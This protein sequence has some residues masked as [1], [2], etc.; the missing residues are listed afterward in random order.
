MKFDNGAK[1]LKRINWSGWSAMRK[2]LLC[3]LSVIMAVCMA[4]V[5]AL[6]VKTLT[7]SPREQI[8]AR[9]MRQIERYGW[10]PYSSNMTIDEFYALME[11][12]DEGKLP[13]KQKSD[14]PAATDADGNGES[15]STP[16]TLIIPRDRFLL[17][18][19]P[20]ELASE[21]MIIDEEN[22]T[23]TEILDKPLYYDRDYRYEP[24][25]PDTGTAYKLG[26]NNKGENKDG[27]VFI[28]TNERG[29][30]IQLT[31]RTENEDTI[32]YKYGRL[33]SEKAV[34]YEHFDHGFT[35]NGNN[36]V[37]YEMEERTETNA[38]G[39]KFVTYG[40]LL[41]LGT[42]EEYVCL[43]N[44]I[45]VNWDDYDPSSGANPE[46]EVTEKTY[47]YDGGKLYEYDESSDTKKGEAYNAAND[48]TLHLF[49]KDGSIYRVQ[50]QLNDGSHKLTLFDTEEWETTDIEFVDLFTSFTGVEYELSSDGKLYRTGTEN[51]MPFSE[52]AGE[53]YR[54]EI[55]GV[56]QAYEWRDGVMYMPRTNIVA[57][58]DPI[59]K[60]LSYR[61]P[62]GYGLQYSG[63]LRPPKDW[64]GVKVEEI[65]DVQTVLVKKGINDNNYQISCDVDQSVFQGDEKGNGDYEHGI[66]Y[67]GYYIKQITIDGANVNI[68]G[69]IRVPETG[70][71]VYYYLSAEEQDWQVST[72]TL[73]DEDKFLI[74]YTPNEYKI[75]YQVLMEG[76]FVHGDDLTSAEFRSKS[77]ANLVPQ[78]VVM[79]GATSAT[80]LNWVDSIFGT[81]SNRAARTTGG[82]YSFDVLV[83]YGYEIQIYIS[84]D[85]II[86]GTYKDKY[87]KDIPD[88]AKEPN[89]DGAIPYTF[90]VD[91][92]HT[93]SRA[94]VEETWLN[95]YRKYLVENGIIDSATDFKYVRTPSAGFGEYVTYKWED[96]SDP[97][98]EV[99]NGVF[100]IM[101]ERINDMQMH[102]S[103][104][105]YDGHDNSQT[106]FPLGKEPEYSYYSGD[107]FNVFADEKGPAS[108]TMNDTFY[109]HFV[110]ANRMI[111]AV[112]K[113]RKVDETP[114]FDVSNILSNSDGAKDRASSATERFG[115]Q[116][117]QPYTKLQDFSG[118]YY[119]ADYLW[120][121]ESDHG[122]LTEHP[123][124]Y[125]Y[126]VYANVEN[127][128][129]W[130]WNKEDAT[131]KGNS[132]QMKP[133]ER[134]GTYYYS[135]VF[136]TN[137]NGGPFTLDALEVNGIP[138]YVPYY[139]KYRYDN[140]G[141]T[142]EDVKRPYFTE[143]KLQ[144]G[145][146][147]TVEYLM[148]FGGSN[149][150]VYR[151]TV[152]GARQNVTVTGL[153][154]M[155]GGG[156]PEFSVYSLSGV[157]D[158]VGDQTD[159]AIQYYHVNGY[160]ATGYQ[161]N[162]VV[163][164]DGSPKSGIRT[165]GDGAMYGANLRFKIAD[166][167]GSPYYMWV[168]T[169]DEPINNQT[170]LP[171]KVD[172]NGNK[173][174]DIGNPNR[175]VNWSEVKQK[176]SDWTD[177]RG[178]LKSQYI[179][180]MDDSNNDDY[181]YYYIHVAQPGELPDSRICLLTVVA[182]TVKYTVRYTASHDP[183]DA[184]IV[185]PESNKAWYG[186]I[187]DPVTGQ[188]VVEVDSELELQYMRYNQKAPNGKN[189]LLD[190]SETS[191]PTIIHDRSTCELVGMI[192]PNVL[193]EWIAVIH[194]YDDNGGAFY[195]MIYNTRASIMSNEY[196]TIRPKDKNN[197]YNFV[198]WVLVDEN[199]LPY[200]LENGE[201]IYFTSGV[202]DLKVY[203]E[204]AVKHS[205]F[206]NDETDIMVFRLMP[207]W[208]PN[209]NP[210]SYS[211][212][213][214]WVDAKGTLSQAE[215][216]DWDDV[217]TEA[218]IGDQLFVFL[219]KDSIPLQNWIASHPTYVFWDA[220]NNATTQFIRDD[221][222]NLI[223]DE[224]GNP[225]RDRDAN[226]K[227]LK[228]ALE[229]YL[230]RQYNPAVYPQ[231]A[232][233]LQ[234]LVNRDYSGYNEA[235][236]LTEPSKWIEDEGGSFIRDPFTNEW[237]H[238]PY[239]Y[240]PGGNGVD[241]FDRLD[242]SI[243]RVNENG[244]T[245][246]IWMYETK[247]GLLFKKSV[248]VEPFT[249]DDEFYFSVIN[250]W[251][252]EKTTDK[253]GN[254]ITPTALLGTEAEPAVYKAYPLTYYN[255]E[256][257][258]WGIYDENGKFVPA[259]DE[260]SML[261]TF[262]NGEIVSIE[263]NGKVLTEKD[264]D[265]YEITGEDGK[266][267]PVTYFTLTN[268][269]GIS[270]YVPNGNYTIVET[271]SKSGGAYQAEVDYTGASEFEENIELPTGELW[272]K[273]KNKHYIPLGEG[274]TFD[275]DKYAGVSQI[276]V[277]VTFLT[278][279]EEIIQ[280]L[281][282]YNRTN[283]L[284]VG[285]SLDESVYKT[286]DP[287][288]S[289][290]DQANWNARYKG[291]YNFI[292]VFA[293]P[294]GQ[295]PLVKAQS[296]SARSATA[297]AAGEE[298]FFNMNIYDGF[299]DNREFVTMKEVIF[300][301]YDADRHG[302]P[303]DIVLDNYDNLWI[304]TFTLRPEQSAALVMQVMTGNVNYWV[305]EP[306]EED[307][308]LLPNDL[309]PKWQ[310][311]RRRGEAV[312]GY[313]NS[314]FVTNYWHDQVPEDP[315]VADYGYLKITVSGGK[316]GESFLFRITNAD[317]RNISVIVSVKS[318]ESTYVY[319][320]I[321][322]YVVEEISG[323]AW[324]YNALG[325]FN[326]DIGADNTRD[327]PFARQFD[328]S[329]N[330]KGWLG[331]ENNEEWQWPT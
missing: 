35:K 92:D 190:T 58:A 276:P 236:V 196:G 30:K 63:Y 115:L 194:Q 32:L 98:A 296:E 99:H 83:P 320:P 118:D 128:G 123:I 167:Y 80:T 2:F 273:G 247:G 131:F 11:L 232:I 126:S 57:N 270:L 311:N 158:G 295:T 95:G 100:Q 18:G 239:I 192:D 77:I 173:T 52:P 221:N 79:Y 47:I 122:G 183:D 82:A 290:N 326:A 331:S 322:S 73:R 191:L 306:V 235:G 193:E 188:L 224:D 179:Y 316:S 59:I 291:D 293:L 24:Y 55:D 33:Y 145:S 216:S 87:N 38:A 255:E 40:K 166:G 242:G 14:A 187:Q 243:F 171:Y 207:V 85:R 261:V 121:S 36:N 13:L 114:M 284:S 237:I 34:D 175:I 75:E 169:K 204:Y 17:A 289:A 9:L 116:S 319:L 150:R 325:T 12:F 248:E 148:L 125:H 7:M 249:G 186:F 159:L 329:S 66:L 266:P 287:N 288:A 256:L 233:I 84:V 215:F 76:T 43:F 301:K 299:N 253:D 286:F 139:P 160:W 303:W 68:L 321:G 97:N 279:Q 10:D 162:V 245:I 161:A 277:T 105:S 154:L 127:D 50:Q 54:R 254:V 214:N 70:R 246:S 267:I 257:G 269:E 178:Y 172:E 71:L 86:T 119:D 111:T 61:Y 163:T 15:N 263:Q 130:G 29:E 312:V 313:K 203:G 280:T 275:D 107:G 155:T 5:T 285:M 72:T 241:D 25:D 64:V 62:E 202:I 181:G 69:I 101:S 328:A 330:G 147:F 26:E 230:Q 219:N 185:A 176:P 315:E 244:G 205:A 113:P 314:V 307:D 259:T 48:G 144:D 251:V 151:F 103:A 268:G 317:N 206:G 234:A 31:L 153:N 16:Q 318:G 229:D 3:A 272:M 109:N 228:D 184:H 211:V 201:Y 298:Y 53:Y 210:Y 156:S 1:H 198:A 28:F 120:H 195:D 81:S 165:G 324:R 283:S 200:G 96:E 42:E 197:G 134:G 89:A 223:L 238:V 274:E 177:E 94:S 292:V 323:W 227:I 297:Y 21:D 281:T 199:F 41:V 218:Q 164:S 104:R 294:T 49:K 226:T 143:T 102:N 23:E 51:D 46:F 300:E 90:H 182:K 152:T 138:V 37:V 19:L 91:I 78:N 308:S 112:L 44:K 60:N 252:G 142:A 174:L 208:T 304:G 22:G 108:L 129:N 133:S 124:D 220:V 305:D 93:S 264:A 217:T 189:F 213:L 8:K 27:D 240:E 209:N 20:A 146:T 106:G 136:Q 67:N 149:Q 327:D 212:V 258:T 250:N 39:E 180:Y 309:E 74:E 88:K 140:G 310:N 45:D 265:G 132:M 168:D 4:A 170:S 262:I 225:Q 222:G 278:G 110:R 271:G 135:Y 231:D 117:I 137:G 302:N 65:G 6:T 141:Q 56:Y 260:L 282:F 157:Y